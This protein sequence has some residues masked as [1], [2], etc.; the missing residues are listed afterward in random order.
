MWEKNLML[1]L[2]IIV[3]ALLWASASVVASDEQDCFQA[4]EP[5]LRIRGCSE[6]IG[7]APDDATAYHNRAFAFALAGEIDNAIED[8]S[9]VIALAPSNASAYANRGRAYASKGDYTRAV[10]DETKAH[11]LM[12]KS[13]AEPPAVPAQPATAPK[14]R[15]VAAK[16][17]AAVPKAKELP[18]ASPSVAPEP[19]APPA[20]SWWSWLWGNGGQSGSKT[21]KP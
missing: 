17:T 8:Y 12:A 3:A 9:K 5:H 4:Q 19:P 11:E 13:T 7:R 16:R 15:P 20:A 18:K 2:L 6:M 10:E 1:Q 14:K 21:A